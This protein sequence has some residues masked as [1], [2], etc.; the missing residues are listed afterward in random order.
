[1]IHFPFT[2]LHKHLSGTLIGLMLLTS[3]CNYP[4][5][6]PKT[7]AGPEIMYTLA[8]QTLAA[9]QTLAHGT[10]RPTVTTLASALEITPS[11]IIMLPTDRTSSPLSPAASPI[12]P[13]D[14]A[15]FVYDVTIPD[16]TILVPNQPFEKVWRIKN[17]GTCIWTPSYRLVFVKG[18][19]FGSPPSVPLTDQYVYPQD[20]IEVSLQLT[21]PA[22]AGTYQGDWM[23]QNDKGVLFGFGEQANLTIWTRIQVT[24]FP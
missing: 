10:P 1:M 4:G 20:E 16:D 24:E 22:K 8:A 13:C 7:P 14:R 21:S 11:P 18:T 12:T 9:Q 23:L 15:R 2:T 3:A 17:N 5:F 6:K 19:S